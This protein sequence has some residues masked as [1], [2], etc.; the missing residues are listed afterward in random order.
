MSRE[1]AAALY[2]YVRNVFFFE[3]ELDKHPCVMLC[4]YEDFVLDPRKMFERIYEF[5]ELPYPQSNILSNVHAKSVGQGG[6][7]KVGEEINKLC[8]D[9]WG[10]LNDTYKRQSIFRT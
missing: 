1:D 6:Q 9:L 5:V 4:K 2:W 7:V 3:L 8:E 10:K